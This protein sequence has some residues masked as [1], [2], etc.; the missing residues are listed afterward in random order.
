MAEAEQGGLTSGARDLSP[1]PI[2]VLADSEP[3]PP[4]T[5][6]EDIGA[7]SGTFNTS[8]DSLGAPANGSGTLSVTLDPGT[9]VN[10]PVSSAKIG[11]GGTLGGGTLQIVAV[12]LPNIRVAVLPV[13]PDLVAPGSVDLSPF[14]MFYGSADF[15]GNFTPIGLI[16][17]ATVSFDPGTSSALLGDPVAGSFSGDLAWFAPVP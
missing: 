3:L 10:W 8:W 12:S 2:A 11:A 5:C 4:A 9:P 17:K 1:E 7:I 6:L 16:T 15:A 13:P 14:L